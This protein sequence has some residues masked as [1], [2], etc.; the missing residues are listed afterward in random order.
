MVNEHTM[1][2][3]CTLSTKDPFVTLSYTL[4]FPMQ[5]KIRS[6]VSHSVQPK[7]RISQV[8]WK[9]YHMVSGSGNL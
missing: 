7:Y 9:S 1:Y 5:T 3:I 2:S 6:P 8:F 4:T